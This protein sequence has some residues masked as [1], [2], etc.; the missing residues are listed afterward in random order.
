MSDD[1]HRYT[2]KI[3]ADISAPDKVLFGATARQAVILGGA[4]GAMWSIWTLV[5]SAVPP[6]LFAA[7]AAMLLLL[8]GLGVSCNRDGVSVDQWLLAALTQACVPRRRAMAPEGVADPPTFLR[9]ALRGRHPSL[10]APLQLPIVGI[11]EAGALELGRDGMAV[12]A[13][14][15]TVNFA[16]RTGAEQELLVSGFAR[17]LNSLTGPVQIT[18]RTAPLDLTPQIGAL[19]DNARTLPHPLLDAAA[20]GHA[21]YLYDIAAS[22]SVLT[23][24]LLVTAHE[25]DAANTP[26]ASRRI[27]DAAVALAG[28][29]IGLKQLDAQAARTVVSAALDPESRHSIGA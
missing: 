11:D 14:A 15:S 4:A 22:R 21:D 7:P 24:T 28:A 2:V 18:S 13:A 27:H 5:Q 16:L 6:L 1:R 3:P 10:P 12:I 25:A 23:R 17:W 19:R 26:R 29:E 9:D 8:L 20:L